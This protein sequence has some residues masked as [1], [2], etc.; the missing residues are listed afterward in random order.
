MALGICIGTLIILLEQSKTKEHYT[1]SALNWIILAALTAA[2]TL[3]FVSKG[4]MNMSSYYVA[5]PCAFIVVNLNPNLFIRIIVAHLILTLLIEGVEYFTDQYLFIYKADDGTELNESLFGGS[6]GVFR[7]K[8]MFQGPLSAVA[9]ALWVAFLI[10]KNPIVVALLF[11]VAFFASGRLGMLTSVVL[12]C[13][14][15]MANGIRSLGKTLPLVFFL[16]VSASLLI[17]M[18]DENRLFFIFNA[19]DFGSDQNIS[20]IYFW[21]TA[22]DYYFG[23]DLINLLFGDYGFIF[24]QEGATEN[25][26][27]RL[28]L[29]CG[30]AGFLIYVVAIFALMIKS[31]RN[32]NLEG[33][34]ISILIIV[35]MNLFPFVQS[36]S[37]A[38]L[39]WVYFF[40]TI[41]SQ[42]SIQFDR[43]RP[44]SAYD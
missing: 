6:L 7:A 13:F 24:Q 38:L 41:D 4:S 23:Y 28:L 44:K 30:I 29:D 8:G 26:F 20:R 15:F 27:L 3:T 14:R 39:F 16:L 17:A 43:M 31:F 10:R 21:G 22:L 32:K 37:S 12:M 33:F 2:W 1:T 11:L 5:I 18:S 42:R 34:L 36:L 19:L 25:D 40:L 9:F 35:L